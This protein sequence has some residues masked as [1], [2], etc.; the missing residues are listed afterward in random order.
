MGKLEGSLTVWQVNQPEV[1]QKFQRG[2][3][4]HHYSQRLQPL[5]L[6]PGP[7]PLGTPAPQPDARR[8]FQA[9]KQRLQAPFPLFS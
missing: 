5:W 7:H 2:A 1:V 6:A 8:A 9:R 3:H 4:D